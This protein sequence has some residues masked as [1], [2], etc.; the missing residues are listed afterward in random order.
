MAKIESSNLPAI[1]LSKAETQ[2]KLAI[3]ALAGRGDINQKALTIPDLVA[4]GIITEE[5]AV[6]LES[7]PPRY[8][9]GDINYPE[10]GTGDGEDGV[11]GRTSYF[12]IAYA[13]SADGSLDFN[14]TSGIYIGTYVDFI[15]TDSPDHTVYAW[16]KF[17]G[18]DGTDGVDGTDGI[19][20]VNG[21]NGETSYLHLKYSD[22]GLTFT[23]NSGEDVGAWLG[24]YVDFTLADS[25]V[26]DDYTWSKI[27]GTE[28]ATG[29]QGNDGI[30]SYSYTAYGDD[31]SGS[32]FS[33]TYTGQYYM[34]TFSSSNPV[35]SVDP[36]DYTWVLI[37]GSDGEDGT[38]VA[39]VPTVPHS[40]TTAQSFGAIF[41]SWE[42][43]AYN[44]QYGTEIWRSQT[45]DIGTAT[46]IAT[47]SGTKYTNNVGEKKAY[48]Y[49]IRN[50]NING[51]VSGYNSATGTPGI[52]NMVMT[53]E[54]FVLD[55]PDAEFQAFTIVNY[56]DEITPDWKLLL[57]GQVIVTSDLSIGQ[58]LSG[59]MRP[60]TTLTI[61]NSS[62]EIGTDSDGLGYINVAGDGG[63]TE[64]DYL[65]MTNGAVTTY[66]YANG[67]HIQYKELRRVERGVVNHGVEVIIPGYF[68]FAPTIYLTPYNISVYNKNYNN[69]NQSLL[70]QAGEVT[71]VVGQEGSWKFT[72]V[73]VLS[74][75]ADTLTQV[76]TINTTTSSN[77]YIAI[78]SFE[79][80]NA[81][82][83]FVRALVSSSRLVNNGTYQKRQSTLNVYA[84]D[85]TVNYV[86]IGTVTKNHGTSTAN[87]NFDVNVTL[88]YSANW[89]F[90]YNFS[91]KDVSGTFPS[92]GDVYE[93]ATDVSTTGQSFNLTTTAGSPSK[94]Q[95]VVNTRP[96][97]D[98]SWTLYQVKYAY[99][100]DYQ[101]E[102]WTIE[103][104]SGDDNGQA[105]IDL[106]DEFSTHKVQSTA[107]GIFDTGVTPVCNGYPSYSTVGSLYAQKSG[108]ITEDLGT[109]VV[110][111]G[112]SALLH[113]GQYSADTI[114]VKG[115]SVTADCSGSLAGYAKSHL[116][117]TSFNVTYYYRRVKSASTTPTNHYQITSVDVSLGATDISIDTAVINYLAVGE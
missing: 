71:A 98:A 105:I 22:D 43:A 29:P 108:T 97:R 80:I 92:G 54:D 113:A 46:L 102:G 36:V 52:S 8:D 59:E 61:G 56:G 88:P 115:E 94:T 32:N 76:E 87:I 47:A 42:Y 67:E 44:G 116:N 27:E 20:G 38:G 1:P 86:L 4:L 13:N 40:L 96:A 17:E 49:W 109:I 24:Q 104:S 78:S 23:G 117:I 84:S 35:Q 100:Y 62:I 66:I 110:N 41:L 34:G 9:L 107:L 28:G 50:R 99:T 82:N 51:V 7:L 74:L 10:T 112:N 77:S 26:F 53:A 93:Y 111:G 101:V 90:R 48:F 37:R 81:T 70:I 21:E 33:L 103:W 25:S 106:P 72:P 60:D 91:S 75:S 73:A 18:T 30:A 15:I 69:Q 14:H 79:Y 58:L 16:N 57:N 114:R 95:L 65:R 2:V 12:H 39:D 3:D 63:I 6:F 68:K 89:I 64:N 31:L 55:N 85:D 45:D 11:D 5:G 19:P 83:A